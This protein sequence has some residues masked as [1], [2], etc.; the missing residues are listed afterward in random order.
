MPKKKIEY[1]WIES[2][3]KY[4]KRVKIGEKWHDVYSVDGKEITAKI[5]E[6]EKAHD[7]CLILN[8]NTT[9]IQYAKEW[10]TVKIA[11]LAPNSKQVYTNTINNH[12]A[13][14]FG[15]MKLTDIRPLNVQKLMAS[16]ADLA[17]SPQ[18]KILFTISQIM[19]IAE[20][21]GLINKNPCKGIKAGGRA[22]Q[23]KNAANIKTAS[24]TCQIR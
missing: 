18:S 24:R 22:V 17:R 1:T 5:K 13:P 12:I 3:Q 16:K 6:L 15:N 9:L 20:Q 10:Y 11:G 2:R 21:N 4:R 23:E 14:F 7:S 19:D 8:H